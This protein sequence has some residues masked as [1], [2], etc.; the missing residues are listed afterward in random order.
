MKEKHNIELPVA[1]CADLDES[2]LDIMINVALSLDPLWENAIG[3][4]WKNKITRQ[5]LMT[6]Y[7]MM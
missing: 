4:N 6:L 5:K 2:Q 7:K 3:K 1:I